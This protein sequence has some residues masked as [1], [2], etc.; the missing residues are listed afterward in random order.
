MSD[1]FKDLLNIPVIGGSLYAAAH[2][3]DIKKQCIDIKKKIA[4]TKGELVVP[5]QNP[6]LISGCIVPPLESIDIVATFPTGEFEITKDR[7]DALIKILNER[8]IHEQYTK[9]ENKNDDSTRFNQK[10]TRTKP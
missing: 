6:R 5:K 2:A 8:L 4:A 7:S 3:A 1:K 10:I 9:Q